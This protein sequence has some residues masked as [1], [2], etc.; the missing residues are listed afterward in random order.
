[1]KYINLIENDKVNKIIAYLATLPNDIMA[2]EER[3]KVSILLWKT[4][5]SKA[6]FAQDFS[7]HILDNLA[8]AKASFKVPK[9]IL[10]ALNHLKNGL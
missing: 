8:D 4:F 5:P 6:E 2:D 7:I 1:M 3:R 10:N 9:Y